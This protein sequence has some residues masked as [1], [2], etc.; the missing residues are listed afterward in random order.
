MVN[1][2]IS[3]I[4]RKT[5]HPFSYC[6]LASVL[7]ATGKPQLVLCFTHFTKEQVLISEHFNVDSVYHKLL[8][9]D[10]SCCSYLKT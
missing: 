9:L 1:C 3:S 2:I 7:A 4:P 8:T 10:Q 6:A 5:N